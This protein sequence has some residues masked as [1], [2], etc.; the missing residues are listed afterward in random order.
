MSDTNQPILGSRSEES[1]SS[2]R[3]LSTGLHQVK[4]LCVNPSFEK[5]AELYG[6][7]P[8]QEPNYDIVEKNGFTYRPCTFYL[9]AAGT[10][11]NFRVNV[12]AEVNGQPLDKEGNP[13]NYKIVTS[14]GNVTWAGKKDENGIV[15][16]KSQFVDH[17][18]LR[19]GEDTIIAFIQ[20]LTAFNY[21][22]GQDYIDL[23]IQMKLTAK[24]LF[25][26]DYSGF[27]NLPVIYPNNVFIVQFLVSESTTGTESKY[28]QN[29]STQADCFFSDKFMRGVTDYH[30]TKLKERHE[31]G[32]NAPKAFDMFEGFFYSYEPT[33]F[34]P[35][36]ALGGVPNNPSTSQTA[37]WND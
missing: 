11:V 20:A 3:V 25:D 9:D 26:G 12:G 7:E 6:R 37:S 1:N 8:K 21:K 18:P 17:T 30:I 19:V 15:Q 31:N 32:L 35:T 4:F 34:D 10:I 16:I 33:V 28:Y 24:C 14:T 23:A 2:P 5:L 36:T 29:I 22:D 27:N 13:R